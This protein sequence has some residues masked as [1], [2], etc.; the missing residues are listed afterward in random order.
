V[1]HTAIG[2]MVVVV[3]DREVVG[4][5]ASRALSDLAAGRRAVDAAVPVAADPANDEYR[6]I[7]RRGLRFLDQA[8]PDDPF[9]LLTVDSP[10][11]VSDA[12]GRAAPR[13]RA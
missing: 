1:P 2:R 11:A 7:V 9:T 10:A 8:V 4:A 3:S 6:E 13:R 12:V 5:A